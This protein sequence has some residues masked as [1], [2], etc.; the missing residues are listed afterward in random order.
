[1]TTI[2]LAPRP[3]RRGARRVHAGLA[4]LVIAAVFVQVY[5]IGAYVFG[6]GQSAL[7]AHRTLGFVAHGFEV[8]TFVAALVARADIL[9]SLALAVVGTVQISLASAHGWVGG[10]HPLF[11]LVVLTLS[12]LIVLRYRHEGA[13]A[14]QRDGR[15]G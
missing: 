3:L 2:E 4:A 9:R 10:L 14:A 8:L 13:R 1:M 6:A 5:L 11:A 15:A 12:A 7:D